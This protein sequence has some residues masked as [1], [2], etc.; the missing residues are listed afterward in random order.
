M[1][2]NIKKAIGTVET[3]TKFFQ[4]ILMRDIALVYVNNIPEHGTFLCS[5]FLCD[6]I[7]LDIA[8]MS[9]EFAKIKF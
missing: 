9:V 5:I 6:L 7:L 8:I 3:K 4:P 2:N 1:R